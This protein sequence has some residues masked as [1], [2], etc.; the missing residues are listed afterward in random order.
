MNEEI[1]SALE[2][3][4][5]L[6]NELK[7]AAKADEL[8]AIAAKVEEY[9]TT[10]TTLAEKAK[11]NETQLLAVKGIQ[12]QIDSLSQ[13][14]QGKSD[15][16]KELS[17]EQ[18]LKSYEDILKKAQSGEQGKAT[19][20]IK[21]AAPMVGSTFFSGNINDFTNANGATLQRQKPLAVLPSVTSRPVAGGESFYVEET[22]RTEGAAFTAEG[23]AATQGDRTYSVVRKPMLKVSEYVKIAKE[24]LSDIPWLAAL[25]QTDL[26]NSIERKADTQMYS[27]TASAGVSYDGITAIA[28][29]VDATKVGT[30]RIANANEFDVLNYV[31]GIVE[32]ESYGTVN[33]ILVN[34]VDYAK[35]VAKMKES[36]NG[37]VGLGLGVDPSII[38]KSAK[39]TAG[40]FLMGD[41]SMAEREYNNGVTV[42]IFNQN[43]D[44]AIKDLV[45]VKATARHTF[46]VKSVNYKCFAKG[47]FSTIIAA[48]TAA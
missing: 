13:L 44:D 9:G 27:G 4:K 2:F 18:E 24:K 29:N 20:E 40:T 12:S 14:I 15:G 47:T 3:V 35:M 39:V 31:I 1:K 26:V 42:E 30:D 28:T 23:A 22:A 38:G 8:K 48:L 46:F 21:A 16:Q 5:G 6:E 37:V 32:N 11:D 36:Q 10:L 43:E 17:V 19:I 25:I 33:R 45:M 34:P 7:N 41:F